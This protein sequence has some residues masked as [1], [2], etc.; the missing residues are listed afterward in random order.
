MQMRRKGM[1]RRPVNKSLSV[2][3]QT[4]PKQFSTRI[5]NKCS[6]TLSLSWRQTIGELKGNE[7]S[8]HPKLQVNQIRHRLRQQYGEEYLSQKRLFEWGKCF[9]EGYLLQ[10]MWLANNN[11]TIQTVGEWI[12]HQPKDFFENGTRKKYVDY[13]GSALQTDICK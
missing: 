1:R 3:A 5:Q 2:H 10:G 7:V 11:S 9:G 4:T 8:T 13:V 12:R 6:N